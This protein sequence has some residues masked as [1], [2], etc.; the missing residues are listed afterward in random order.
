M[1]LSDSFKEDW[2]VVV[3]VE[4]HDVDF[5]EEFVLWAVVDSDGEVTSVIEAAELR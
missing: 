2:E 1:L 4:G 5:P 3:V